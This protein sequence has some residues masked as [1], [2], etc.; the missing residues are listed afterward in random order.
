M[1]TC[2]IK[3]EFYT[4][5]VSTLGAELIS[6]KG[7]DGFEYMWQ[8]K[9]GDGFWDSHAPILFPAC[10][11]LLNQKYTFG[12]TLYAMDCTPVKSPLFR[13]SIRFSRGTS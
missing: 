9:E 1:K 7:A 10:G 2:S 11:R 4:I 12:G 6:I 3:N 13:K 5:T 8:A